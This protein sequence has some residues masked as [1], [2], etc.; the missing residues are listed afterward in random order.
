LQ[1]FDNLLFS[2]PSAQFG[3]ISLAVYIHGSNVAAAFAD[4]TSRVFNLSEFT[5]SHNYSDLEVCDFCFYVGTDD[6]M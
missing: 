3:S 2:D 5:D 4:M 6:D 1:S